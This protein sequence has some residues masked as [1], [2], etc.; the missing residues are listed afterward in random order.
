MKLFKLQTKKRN[1]YIKFEAKNDA[2]LKKIVG[3][4]GTQTED[5]SKVQ[6]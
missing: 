6:I 5:K 1:Q 3:G 4:E 2:Y